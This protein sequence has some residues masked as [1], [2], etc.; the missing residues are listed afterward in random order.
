MSWILSN[1]LYGTYRNEQSAKRQARD[2]YLVVKYKDETYEIYPPDTPVGYF[3]GTNTFILAPANIVECAWRV[4][5]HPG[6]RKRFVEVNITNRKKH[7]S[8][9]L[10][11]SKSDYSINPQHDSDTVDYI[12]SQIHARKN[13]GV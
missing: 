2:R 1:G 10:T 5:H 3:D 8:V 11:T 6:T 7:K 4:F 13:Q 12:A 9:K